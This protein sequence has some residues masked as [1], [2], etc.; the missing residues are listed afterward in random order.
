MF[1][2]CPSRSDDPS[3]QLSAAW[4]RESQLL[5]RWTLYYNLS[6]CTASYFSQ[7]FSFSDNIRNWLEK[8]VFKNFCSAL[9]TNLLLCDQFVHILSS[10]NLPWENSVGE[11][12]WGW[13][14]NIGIFLASRLEWLQIVNPA[15]MANWSVTHVDWSKREWHPKSYAIGDITKRTFSYIQVCNYLYNL[16]SVAAITVLD[17]YSVQSPCNNNAHDYAPFWWQQNKKRSLNS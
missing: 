17:I 8:L 4:S 3:L 9:S 14:W 10:C 16:G 15:N 7:Q 11:G 12:F 1:V 5:S 6:P 13:S 2:A